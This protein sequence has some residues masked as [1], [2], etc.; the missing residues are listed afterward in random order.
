MTLLTT[1]IILFDVNLT[2]TGASAPNLKPWRCESKTIMITEQISSI[3]GRDT[4][5]N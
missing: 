5:L 1:G 4:L 3:D 2:K